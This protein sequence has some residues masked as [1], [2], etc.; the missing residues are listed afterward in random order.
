MAII[1]AKEAREIAEKE[2]NPV[3]TKLK[4]ISDLI[5]TAAE[6]GYMEYK[7]AI[8][9]NEVGLRVIAELRK[10]GYDVDVTE[11]DGVLFCVITW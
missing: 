5:R 7:A 8:R 4:D 2:S 3:K 9:D 1:T 10:Y 11:L 6:S